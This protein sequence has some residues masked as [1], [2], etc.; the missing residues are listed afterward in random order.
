MILS[1]RGVE[2]DLIEKLEAL[3]YAYRPDVV[4][5]HLA[6]FAERLDRTGWNPRMWG[7]PAAEVIG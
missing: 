6:D 4:V 3:K 1:E 5:E 7:E 2:D